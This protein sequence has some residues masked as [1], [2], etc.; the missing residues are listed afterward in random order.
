VNYWQGRDEGMWISQDGLHHVPITH[1]TD[2][3][4]SS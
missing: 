4:E 2:P 1:G 3:D